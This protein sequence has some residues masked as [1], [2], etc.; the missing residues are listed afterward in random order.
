MKNKIESDGSKST[1][2]IFN[3]YAAKKIFFQ[4]SVVESRNFLGKP[5]LELVKVI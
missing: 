3:F 2:S 1:I 5:A 4:D